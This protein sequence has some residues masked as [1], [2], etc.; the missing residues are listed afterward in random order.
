MNNSSKELITLAIVRLRTVK[1]VALE[2][3]E[4]GSRIQQEVIDDLELVLKNEEQIEQ[5]NQTS[6]EVFG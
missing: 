3:W 6:K 1:A 5:L 2:G 4:N